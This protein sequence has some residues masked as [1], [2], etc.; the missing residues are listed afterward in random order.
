[1]THPARILLIR[2]SALG[3]VCRSVPVLASLRAA[4]PTATIDW[5]VQDSFA[6]AIS[7]HPALS[8]V[9]PFARKALGHS[10]KNARPGPALAFLKD[11]RIRR[12]DLVVEAQGLARSGLFAFATGAP[13]RIGFAN[14]RELG[15]LGLTERF[16]VSASMHSVDRMLELLRLAGVPPVRDMRLYAPEQDRAAVA[17]DTSLAPG[18]FVLLAP[19]SRWP[20][21]RWPATR[22]A[23]LARQLLASTATSVVIVGSASERDQCGPLLDLATEN[24]RVIDLIGA[25][26]VGRLLAIVERSALVV[27]NDSAVLHMAVGFERPLVALYG[28]TSIDLVGPYQRRADVIQ[29]LE[30]T[31]SFDHKDEPTGRRMMDRI[32][33]DE[34]AAAA[35]ARLARTQLTTAPRSPSPSAAPARP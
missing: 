35:H 1:M 34:V 27:A 14:A 2:P 17:S 15:W 26:T 30:P 31:D 9:I 33:V 22:F 13:R 12:Y 3:D 10:V 20:G 8:G 32:S 6:P 5:L 18:S 28:P 16:P 19:T 11:L 24:S 25:T 21:K 7:A 4:Y 29:H 23:E